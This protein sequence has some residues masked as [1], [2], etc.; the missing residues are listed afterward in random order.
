MRPAIE[1]LQDPKSKERRRNAAT[2]TLFD[3]ARDN[4]VVILH[5]YGK[6]DN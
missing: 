5:S 3:I 1:Y 6:L 4:L 2:N